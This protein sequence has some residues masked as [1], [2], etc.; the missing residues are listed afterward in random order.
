MSITANPVT[1]NS[2]AKNGTLGSQ[3]G[4]NSDE[5]I[6]P[7]D[8]TTNNGN[9]V[10]SPVFTGRLVTIRK[11]LGTEETRYMISDVTTT[12]VQVV[13]DWGTAPASG[14]AY[15][16]CYI[17][18]DVDT[19]GNNW[20]V[21]S[22]RVSDWVCA[23]RFIVANTGFFG[24]LDRHSLE[25]NDNGSTTVADV[26][27]NSGGRFFIG[28]PVGEANVG[29]GYIVATPGTDGEL[30]MDLQSG[31]IVEWRDFLFTCVWT[32]ESWWNGTARLY[33]GQIYAAGYNMDFYGTIGQV[34]HITG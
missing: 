22:K 2:A 14:D 31:G 3:T 18:V 16:V 8:M 1:I 34:A 11:G 32:C 24:L 15:E 13:E 33:N 9:L 12:K 26:I 20:K 19:I 30:A 25:T 7:S 10:S 28:Y 29:G 4:A 27:V 5:I 6:F 17:P 23:T 21:L